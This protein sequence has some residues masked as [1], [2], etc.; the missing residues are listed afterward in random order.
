[1]RY[2]ATDDGLRYRTPVEIASDLLEDGYDDEAATY[3]RSHGVAQWE[4][5]RLR[6]ERAAAEEHERQQLALAEAERVEREAAL[7]RWWAEHRARHNCVACGGSGRVNE[8]R[9]FQAETARNVGPCYRSDPCPICG[10]TGH[11][12]PEAVAV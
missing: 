6:S 7:A 11:V 4:I 10:G 5:E 12:E 9:D 1:M 8:Y 3:M 2:Y